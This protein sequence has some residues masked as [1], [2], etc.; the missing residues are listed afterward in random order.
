[1]IPGLTFRGLL[2][3]Y[4][5]S[6]I[7]PKAPDRDPVPLLKL[8]DLGISYRIEVLQGEGRFSFLAILLQATPK[9]REVLNERIG[10]ENYGTNGIRGTLCDV[11]HRTAARIADLIGVSRGIEGRIFLPDRS[12]AMELNNLQ[13]ERIFE[14]RKQGIRWLHAETK[15]EELQKGI[16]AYY[17][18]ESASIEYHDASVKDPQGAVVVIHDIVSRRSLP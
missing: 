6:L 2:R 12:A 17:D 16:S 8:S 13:L 9:F 1:M 15:K 3:S 7:R 10:K 5:T 4:F 11:D 18:L 14:L